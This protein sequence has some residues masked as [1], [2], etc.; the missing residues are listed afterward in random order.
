MNSIGAS[1][2]VRL[3]FH[4]AAGTVTGSKFLLEVD[5]KKIL[6]D[7][8]LFQ[9]KKELRERNWQEPTFKPEELSAI[10][11][12][13]AHIDH[14]GYL[15]LVVK[16]G[17]KGPIYATPATCA[18]LTLLLPDSAHLQEEE[19]RFANKHGTSRHKPAK[20]LYD[21]RDVENTFE[22]IKPIPRDEATKLFEKIYVT[23][24]CAGH[25]LGSTSLTME[26]HGKQIV[27]SG[28]IG[29]Y[30]TPILAD[31][32][33]V[34]FGDLLLCESTYGD[35]L[36][37]TRDVE[38]SLAECINLAVDKNG[39]I[40]IPSFAIGRTQ[41]LLYWLASLERAG[42]IPIL[43]VYVDSPMA[44]NATSLYQKFRHDYDE[45]A[46]ELITSGETPLLTERTTF[47]KAVEDSK[48]LNFEKGVRIVISASGMVTGGRILHHM[49][50]W[51]PQKETTVLFV[52]YQAEGTR[53][54]IIQSGARTV[55]IF[56]DDVLIKADIKTI[57]GLSA[58]GDKNELS[59]WL[60]SSQGSPKKVKIIHGEKEAASAFAT[61]LQEDFGWDATPAKHLETVEI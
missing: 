44:V 26:A 3:S 60:K 21:N 52:G 41:N 61:H 32:A 2:T 7:C 19:A 6:I 23:P 28:D 54:R 16:R 9:G 31:P 55:K 56:S 25:I 59:R 35:R 48:R 39:P 1:P 29:R 4:G 11:L 40:I 22:L 15:P 34:E 30:D 50:N 42:K 8:G 47:C 18:L 49:K 5:N 24:R 53:G 58:H 46:I 27:F 14:T 36:H 37:D 38:D 33:P 43:P 20:P 51:L 45:E 10:V 57:S 12:T 17:F 13:H